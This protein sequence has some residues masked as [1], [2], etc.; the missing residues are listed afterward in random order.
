[1]TFDVLFDKPGRHPGQ[2]VGR[3]PYLQPVPVIG[4]ASLIGEIAPVTVTEVRTNS[5]YGTLTQS[6]HQ[7]APQFAEAVGV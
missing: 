3:S 6:P 4:P 1:M 5:L 7:A 2:I